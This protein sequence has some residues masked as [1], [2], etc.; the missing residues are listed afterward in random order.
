MTVSVR[1][2]GNYV[3]KRNL[4]C[5]QCCRRDDRFWCRSSSFWQ[6]R[7]VV[8]GSCRCRCRL[9]VSVIGVGA[10]GVGDAVS[11]LFVTVSVEEK[12]I[13]LS[14]VVVGCRCRFFVVVGTSFG[15]CW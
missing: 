11:V 2:F 14:V 7:L 6:I 8:V 5:C 13:V 12:S 1:T 10:G 15:L 9:S 4:S 3:L